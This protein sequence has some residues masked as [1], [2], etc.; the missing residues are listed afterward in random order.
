M[1]SDP[2]HIRC[3]SCD[4]VVSFPASQAGSTQEC[5]VCNAYIDVPDSSTDSYDPNQEEQKHEDQVREFNRQQEIAKKQMEQ[6][7]RQLDDWEEILQ[8]KQQE[9][10][11]MSAMIDR[12][13]AIAER[14]E[15]LLARWETD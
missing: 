2:I 8:R 3:E 15:K 10:N 6:Y 4:N 14:F 11:K 13:N 5:A 12:W 7:Q 9:A 1:P